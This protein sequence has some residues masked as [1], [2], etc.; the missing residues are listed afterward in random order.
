MNDIVIYPSKVQTALIAFA[1]LACALVCGVV[2]V[3][4][5]EAGTTLEVL[6]FSAIVG[7]VL[8][9]TFFRN[10]YRLFNPTPCLL[11]N[12]QGITETASTDKIGLIRWDEISQVAVYQGKRLKFLGISLADQESFFNRLPPD[13]VSGLKASLQLR[14]IPIAIPQALLSVPV[15]DLAQRIIAYR[16]ALT[17]AAGPAPPQ[18]SA[19]PPVPSRPPSPPPAPSAPP[20]PGPSLSRRCPGCGSTS[21]GTK[22][23][24][25]CG[26]PM[27][28]KRECSNCGAKVKATTKF[29]PEC[30]AR[31]V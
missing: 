14:K 26:Q 12:H 24:P 8:L 2:V 30:G 9:G 15:E 21:Q 28:E 11:V 16:Q 13:K 20:P 10:L 22:F 27:P 18:Y 6:A 23:C 3:F 31:V 25:N 7:T 1:S 4:H 19:P 17:A 29:C 5:N